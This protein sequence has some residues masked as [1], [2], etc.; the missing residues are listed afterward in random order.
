MYFAREY[1]FSNNAGSSASVVKGPSNCRTSEFR[2]P[3]CGHTFFVTKVQ[4]QSNNTASGK[5]HDTR[6]PTEINTHIDHIQYTWA[7]QSGRR[8]AGHKNRTRHE[9][10]AKRIPNGGC[11]PCKTMGLSREQAGIYSYTLNR[12]V[13]IHTSN[14]G[15]ALRITSVLHNLTNYSGE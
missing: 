1:Q 4:T 5:H 14:G 9:T 6:Y 15:Q 10:L 13:W 8:T 2:C 12:P 11:V 3:R 7:D